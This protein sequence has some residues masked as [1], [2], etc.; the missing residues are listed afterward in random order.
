MVDREI[1]GDIDLTSLNNDDIMKLSDRGISILRHMA[2][3]SGDQ[4]LRHE[5]NRSKL[6]DRS[7]ELNTPGYWSRIQSFF[8]GMARLGS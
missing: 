5:L 7:R 8:T 4:E 3:L 1:E 2:S 6:G